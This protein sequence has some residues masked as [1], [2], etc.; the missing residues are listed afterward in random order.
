MGYFKPTDVTIIVIFETNFI[1]RKP[2]TLFLCNKKN[3]AGKA[4]F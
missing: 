3:E 2:E 4:V 1:C